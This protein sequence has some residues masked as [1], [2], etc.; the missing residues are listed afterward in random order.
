MATTYLVL[1][2]AVLLVVIATLWLGRTLVVS[3]T[4]LLTAAVL[5]VTTLIFDALLI[6]L[7][8]FGYAPSKIL[9]VRVFDAPLEDFFYSILAAIL[10][11]SLWEHGRKEK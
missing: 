2:C 6:A 4:T 10:I 3:R 8:M 1:N 9:G 11:P 7:G 5:L